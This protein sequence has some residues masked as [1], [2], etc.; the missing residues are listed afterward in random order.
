MN[1]V[2]A[3]MS[4]DLKDL[5]DCKSKQVELK[6]TGADADL[7]QAA[8]TGANVTQSPQSSSAGP[9]E[10]QPDMPVESRG[11]MTLNLV[12]RSQPKVNKD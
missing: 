8:T 7:E 3:S 12:V 1:Q 2:I 10:L 11:P 9:S 4:I 5:L 6:M